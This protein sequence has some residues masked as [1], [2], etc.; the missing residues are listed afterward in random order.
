[1]MF[2]PNYIIPTGMDILID[3]V[4]QNIFATGEGCYRLEGQT[5]STGTIHYKELVS[6]LQR[7]DAWSTEA[8]LTPSSALA[9]LR[10]GGS[11]CVEQLS[12]ALKDQI[13]FRRALCIAIDQMAAEVVKIT[14]GSLSKPIN[15]KRIRDLSSRIYTARP[16]D[17]GLRGGSTR[18]VAIMPKAKTLMKYQDRFEESGYDEMVLADQTWLRANR[19]R[20][21]CSKNHE[22]ILTAIDET[23]LDLKQP[24]AAQVLKRNKTILVGENASRALQ[25]LEPIEPVSYGT[26]AN[27][28][29]TMGPTAQSVARNG[30][31]HVA[32]NNT[33][34]QTD[35]RALM[36]GEFVE[37]DECKLSL[38]E[39]VLDFRPVF[40]LVKM[41]Y[42][43]I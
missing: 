32:N 28:V 5:R 38:I 26:I 42:V 16:I 20:R 13:D 14:R 39:V 3:G 7:P 29:N 9:H 33:P 11:F 25:G 37:I 18:T 23:F 40:S 1:M 43:F 31:K 12:D 36:L 41:D 21:I 22:L 24:S 27:Y 17:V 35:T 10:V 8:N 2:E 15:R 6:L 30:K 34:G 19:S 4:R